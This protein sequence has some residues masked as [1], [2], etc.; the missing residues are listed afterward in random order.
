MF[1]LNLTILIH[2][3]PWKG[4]KRV[5]HWKFWKNSNE[6]VFLVENC[7]FIPNF[8]YLLA[9]FL[10]INILGEIYN[11]F[12]YITPWKAPK[13]QTFEKN[14]SRFV[15]LVVNYAYLSNLRFLMSIVRRNN[16]LIESYNFLPTWPPE[17][18][19]KGSSTENFGKI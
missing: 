2:V 16:V 3:T 9:I 11:F 4:Q 5:K 6:F 7:A 17:K 10:H 13:T 18:A 12:T 8:S 19:Q 14:S 15:F 1:W